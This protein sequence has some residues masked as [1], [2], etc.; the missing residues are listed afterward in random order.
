MNLTVLIIL[1]LVF[2]LFLI[3]F[4]FIPVVFGRHIIGKAK[5]MGAKLI[6]FKGKISRKQN[7]SL[8][9]FAVPTITF[10]YGAINKNIVVG[11][12]GLF[13]SIL[14]LIYI[15][16]KYLKAAGVYENGL[17]YGDFLTWDKIHSWKTESNGKISLLLKNGFNIT[18]E[19]EIDT[20]ALS[21][22][23]EEKLVFP[24]G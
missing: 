23:L 5:T 17:I 22:I 21:R 1:Y 6:S 20:E 2:F 24:K 9:L 7:L 15:M 12:V 16:L 8:G 19:E 3:I 13:L 11:L 18:I 10:S 4:H 14:M